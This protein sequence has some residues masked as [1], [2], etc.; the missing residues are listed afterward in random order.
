MGTWCNCAFL[1]KS[2][3][4][5]WCQEWCW[6]FGYISWLCFSVF[7]LSCCVFV[8]CRFSVISCLQGVSF[9]EASLLA[10]TGNAQVAQVVSVQ[11]VDYMQYQITSQGDSQYL[12]ACNAFAQFI[13]VLQFP[14]QGYWRYVWEAN[15]TPIFISTRQNMT[16]TSY[17]GG[18]RW[19]HHWSMYIYTYISGL[20]ICIYNKYNIYM[21]M[22]IINVN[23]YLYIQ[24]VYIYRSMYSLDFEDFGF[25]LPTGSGWWWENLKQKMPILNLCQGGWS[26]EAFGGRIEQALVSC[27][28][29]LFVYPSGN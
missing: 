22:W 15:M 4:I 7:F 24:Y 1:R 17:T 18:H 10:G 14:S 9:G 5:L 26:R 25:R 27:F 20:S 21:Y 19:F 23:I 6:A 13:D 3:P 16:H 12:A 11:G 8:C 2:S 28:V 29:C